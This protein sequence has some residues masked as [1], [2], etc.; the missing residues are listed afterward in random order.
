[1]P[2]ALAVILPLLR[3]VLPV[4]AAIDAP[5]ATAIEEVAEEDC[6]V[7]VE[8]AL[9]EGIDALEVEI[10][11]EDSEGGEGPGAAR[12]GV[13]IYELGIGYEGDVV[14]VGFLRLF[15]TLAWHVLYEKKM[16]TPNAP[17]T[18]S[19]MLLSQTCISTALPSTV[20]TPI[21]FAAATPP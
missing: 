10:G 9:E 8:V 15:F 13:R 18:A 5:F 6:A 7:G 17:N 20:Y 11:V 16:Y 1:M 2:E 14:W 19:H 21:I 12:V 4:G 3:R